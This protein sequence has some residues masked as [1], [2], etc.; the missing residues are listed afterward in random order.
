MLVFEQV[1]G[2]F[3]ANF[4]FDYEN[5]FPCEAWFILVL[6]VMYLL[7]YFF[8][9]KK[10]KTSNLNFLSI[11]DIVSQSLIFT[12]FKSVLILVSVVIISKVIN[13][14]KIK[15]IAELTRVCMVVQVWFKE[16][17][18][19]IFAVTNV[20]I[21]FFCLTIYPLFETFL[22]HIFV[23][24]LYCIV[25]FILYYKVP[26]IEIFLC[27]FFS[28]RLVFSTISVSYVCIIL[29]FLY[30]YF[31]LESLGFTEIFSEFLQEFIEGKKILDNHK[32]NEFKD[33]M[34]MERACLLYLALFISLPLL[35]NSGAIEFFNLSP[36]Y[37]NVFD[38]IK[39]IVYVFMLVG[40]LVNL[41]IIW[42]FNP[43]MKTLM[44]AASTCATCVG[45]VCT[46]VL[47]TDSVVDKAI[48]GTKEPGRNPV[49]RGIQFST[50]QCEA[51]TKNDLQLAKDHWGVFGTRP[52][53]VAGTNV[54][55]PGQT[56][57]RLCN[58]TT[59]E[60]KALWSYH[61]GNVPPTPG[62]S[63]FPKN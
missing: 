12:G 61:R 56:F 46:L 18:L 48:G 51:A 3:N 2:F 58:H 32:D 27:L 50:Y 36:Q 34:V 38:C 11:L 13:D 49:I 26:V 28:Y 15:H 17:Q 41:I 37:E 21:F 39:L 30:I 62:K 20:F 1:N 42:I 24:G 47:A 60:Q 6:F 59:P 54:V 16:N 53:V 4:Y 9:V 10:S 25:Y 8:F 44:K 63:W 19:V 5:K 7:S 23:L 43:K 57:D 29:G 14:L 35:N 45:A 40:F 52:P 22:A 33:F 55:D 31:L